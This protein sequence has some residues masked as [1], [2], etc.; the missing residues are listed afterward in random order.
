MSA[1]LVLRSVMPV[2]Q[3]YA[4]HFFHGGIDNSSDKGYAHLCLEGGQAV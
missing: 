1:G 4:R 2:R 3:V